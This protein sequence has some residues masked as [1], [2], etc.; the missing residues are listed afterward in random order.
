MLRPFV[1]ALIAAVVVTADA[2]ACIITDGYTGIL[3]DDIPVDAAADDVV[4]DVEFSW[5]AVRE[6]RFT[7]AVVTAHVRR[8]VRGEFH[9]NTVRVGLGNSSCDYPFIFGRRGLLIGHFVT[10]DEGQA[11]NDQA[12]ALVF[13]GESMHFAWPF[14]E[15][16][17]VPKSET[18]GHRRRRT[19]NVRWSM[20]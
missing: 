18:V 7:S 15:I 4:L 6:S 13:N 14:R 16:V 9:G 2:N 11:L 20:Y 10:P 8:V 19:G 1:L 17:F 3:F 12:P 5:Q